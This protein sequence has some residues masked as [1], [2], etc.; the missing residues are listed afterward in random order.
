MVTQ[1]EI[2]P[3][4]TCFQHKRTKIQEYKRTFFCVKKIKRK[5]KQQPVLKERERIKKEQSR[6]FKTQFPLDYSQCP[7]FVT[8]PGELLSFYFFSLSPPL[9]SF[10]PSHQP[11]FPCSCSFL[12]F[13]SLSFIHNS[14][15]FLQDSFSLFT[16]FPF[17]FP[18]FLRIRFRLSSVLFVFQCLSKRHDSRFEKKRERERETWRKNALDKANKKSMCSNATT[19]R[20]N[21]WQK[22]W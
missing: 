22:R 12:Y 13:F 4:I 9:P 6:K 20:R 11:H 10:S 5:N 8:C 18:V 19:T 2:F 1:N 3:I 21:N 14:L 7:S 16:Y 15:Y 17:L